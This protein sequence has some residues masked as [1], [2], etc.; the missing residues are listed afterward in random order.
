MMM[1]AVHNIHNIIVNVAHNFE[2]H[3][4]VQPGNFMHSQESL[5]PETPSTC[6]RFVTADRMMLQPWL[7]V[8]LQVVALVVVQQQLLELK[9]GNT[10]IFPCDHHRKSSL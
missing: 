1:G 4:G 2:G 3:V 5:C 8:L 9:M 10:V 6:R 7:R